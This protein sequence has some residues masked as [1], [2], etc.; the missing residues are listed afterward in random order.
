MK[1]LCPL[2]RKEC[3]GN[4]CAMWKEKRCLVVSFVEY[5]I[6]PAPEQSALTP[7]V[8]TKL[9]TE[10]KEEPEFD[11]SE[12]RKPRVPDEV[13]KVTAEERASELAAFAKQQYPN[14]ARVWVE[15][16]SNYF[17]K[18]KKL[19]DAYYGVPL[20]I[21]LK[22]RKAERIAQSEVDKEEIEKQKSKLSSLTD[23][24]VQW[25][26]ELG[27]RKLTLQDVEV[28]LVQEKVQISQLTRRWLYTMVNAAL[29]S[30]LSKE[31]KKPEK[32]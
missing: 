11:L 5:F 17:W 30:K 3:V 14:E 20:E 23:S 32:R 8:E 21:Q 29:K 22:M 4:Q 16:I 31:P 9:I 13:K 25:A 6:G 7:S 26:S 1:M 12:E 10:T 19:K 28:F 24:C 15:G 18:K 27:L 2:L